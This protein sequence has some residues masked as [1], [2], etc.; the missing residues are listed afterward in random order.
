MSD[1]DLPSV[2]MI[3]IGCSIIVLGIIIAARIFGFI[4]PLTP[5]LLIIAV[6]AIVVCA[7]VILFFSRDSKKQES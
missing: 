7:A 1:W 6:I 4:G 5:F 2:A 3:L